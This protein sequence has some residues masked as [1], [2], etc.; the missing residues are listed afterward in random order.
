MVTRRPLLLS[1]LLVGTALAAG[2]ATAPAE[3]PLATL[4]YIPGLDPASMDRS[5]DPCVDFYAFSCGGWRAKNPIPPDQGAW[6]VYAK[7]ESDIERG[8][9]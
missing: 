9:H 5:V 8:Q 2:P 6:S 1:T 3:T 4:P 7:L